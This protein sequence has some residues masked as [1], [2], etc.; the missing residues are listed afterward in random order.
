[1]KKKLTI[2]YRVLTRHE[3]TNSITS[4]IGNSG[5]VLERDVYVLRLP[6]IKGIVSIKKIIKMKQRETI[7]LFTTKRKQ[8]QYFDHKKVNGCTFAARL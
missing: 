4:I 7:N 8:T 6:I 5:S 2:F 3:N 1:M